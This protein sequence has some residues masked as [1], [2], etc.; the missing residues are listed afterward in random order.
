MTIFN[1]AYNKDE[2]GRPSSRGFMLWDGKD[3]GL[4][5]QALRAIT[6]RVELRGDA[7]PREMAVDSVLARLQSIPEYVQLF[8]Q[9][10]PAEADSVA[11][12]IPRAGCKYDPTPLQSVITR[13]T[14]A[15]AIA[16]F[17]R[18]LVTRHSPYD[19]Y[20]AG[21]DQALAPAQ[22]RGLVLFHTKARC[23]TCHQGPEFS[24]GTFKVQGVQQLG[25]GKELTT[26]FVGTPRPSGHDL[27]R[28]LTSGNVQDRFAFRVVTLRQLT[29]TAPYMHDGAL[30]TL[31]E[32]IEF[33]DRGAGDEPTI[34]RERIA[35]ELVPLG[36]TSQEKA[37]LL[38]FLHG[39]TDSS[40]VVE[41]PSRVPSGLPPAGEG[42]LEALAA[43]E[44][45][46]ALP[47]EGMNPAAGKPAVRLA[48]YPN[49]FN[50]Q[51]AIAY[52][53]AQPAQVEIRVY[54]VLGQ[55][56]RRLFLG[57]QPAGSH[58]IYWD[59]RDDAGRPVSSG[60]YLVAAHLGRTPHVHRVLLLR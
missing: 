39:L 9:A 2:T 50:A 19:R 48:N 10:F 32:V 8:A 4:E 22:K 37:D 14:L 27:G 21:D 40:V 17:E 30:A 51:T 59:G 29:L 44:R 25:P 42:I 20:L 55:P 11:R 13:S 60:P 18:E 12:Q 34:G 23:A 5:G 45:N 43:R 38:A 36:L 28:F 6:V 33:Y 56:L 26:T 57:W 53:L 3:R 15:R 41:I 1:I 47:R 35:P 49:P 31:E 46:G 7:F 58:L 52:E 54:N 24:D 16:A